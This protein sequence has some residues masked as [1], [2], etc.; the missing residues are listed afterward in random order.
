MRLSTTR[1]TLAGAAALILALSLFVAGSL[2]WRQRAELAQAE[3]RMRV[4][5][6]ILAE[7]TARSFEAVDR[8][9]VAANHIYVEWIT[10][11]LATDRDA[12]LALRSLKQGTTLLINIAWYDADGK[13][14]M[15]ATGA[16]PSA[17]SIADRELF[18]EPQSDPEQG[19]FIS[20]PYRSSQDGTWLVSVSRRLQSPE[21]KFAGIVRGTMDI[22]YFG[23]IYR[24]AGISEGTAALL[25]LNDRTVLAR[26]PPVEEWIGKVIPA[27]GGGTTYSGSMELVSPLDGQVRLAS[28]R[29][30]AGLPLAI[31]VSITRWDALADWRSDLVAVLTLFVALAAAIL[32]CAWV[33]VRHLTQRE[34]DQRELMQAKAQAETANQAKTEFLATMSHEIRTPMNGIIGYANLLL[35]A[36]TEPE[37]RRH[38]TILRDSG[39]ALLTIINDVLDLSRIEAGKLELQWIDFNL[40]QLI[41]GTVA[42]IEG[43]AARKGLK[44]A[45]TFAPDVPRSAKG[46]PNRLR[47]IV[48]NL[49]SNA[50]KFTDRGRVDVSVELVSASDDALRLKVEVADTGIGIP[51]DAQASLF[52]R[53]QQINTVGRRHRGG[54]GLGL[55]ITKRFVEAMQ[56]EIGHRRRDGGG[57]VFWFT[58]GL[59]RAPTA[60]YEP[61]P[62]PRKGE[63]AT[64]SRAPTRILVVDDLESNRKLVEAL[65]REEGLTVDLADGGESALAAVSANAYDLVLMDVSMPGMD[66]LEATARIR[67][68]P[69]PRGDVPVV[70]LTAAAMPEDVERCIAAGMRGHVAKPVDRNELLAT[71]RRF[72]MGEGAASVERAGARGAQSTPI[73]SA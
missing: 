48:L 29:S 17:I 15:N 7:H 28:V 22:G 2:L 4:Y 59:R 11:A 23:K 9:L 8:T 64:L 72:A 24:S 70:A 6:S 26:E 31:S 5:A 33:F 36:L 41:E 49:L 21:R 65:L 50:V 25:A 16:H 73:S 13:F 56:G 52:H 53:F 14:I 37:L 62:A 44:I 40:A 19:L 42:V 55:A 3:Q 35:D 68:L 10:G 1:L 58:V 45:L 51:A 34:I 32:A 20:H 57:S 27:R 63:A 54:T 67:V 43:E 71:V 12:F 61:E 30:I 38:A 66:G 47:Q 39:R 69:S 46:D 60:L 18:L